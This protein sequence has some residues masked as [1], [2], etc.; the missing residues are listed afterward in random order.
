MIWVPT[1]WKGLIPMT[2]FELQ[3]LKF[4][5]L[6]S[7]NFNGSLQL[8]KIQQ[9]R[10][11]FHLDLSYISLFTEYNGN[12]SSLLPSFPQITTLKLSSCMLK[13]FPYFLRN[14]SKWKLTILDLSNNQIQ[15]GSPKWIWKLLVIFFT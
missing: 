3:D 2:V 1:N 15:Q 6:S 8:N 5:S 7:N 10:N 11:L 4:L 14:Q 9:L 12:N 13:V